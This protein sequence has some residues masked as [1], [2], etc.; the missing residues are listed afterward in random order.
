MKKTRT[1]LAVVLV[2]ALLFSLSSSALALSVDIDIEVRVFNQLENMWEVLDA[3]EAEAL[4]QG[5]DREGVIAAVK[6]AAK[7]CSLVARRTITDDEEGFTFT[8]LLGSN[9]AYNYRLRMYNAGSDEAASVNETVI[10]SNSRTQTASNTN[11]LLVGPYYGSDSSF[12]D[13]YKTEAQSIASY[14]GGTYTLLSGTNA[15]ATSIGNALASNGIVIFDS[16]G[17]SYNNTSY[18][19]IRSSTGLTSSDLSSSSGYHA[20]SLG[21][22]QYGIDGTLMVNKSSGTF[23]GSI[24]WMAICEGMMT[25]GLCDPLYN[26]GAEVVY[27]YSQSVSF[28]GDYAFEATFWTNMKNGKTVASSIAA[29]KSAHGNYDT[30]TDPNAYPVVRSDSDSYPSNPDSVQTVYSDWVLP[31]AGGTTP[32]ATP[33][34]APTATATP[35]ATAT[36]AP[37]GSDAYIQTSTITAGKEYII[38]YVSGSTAYV[39]TTTYQSTSNSRYPYLAAAS[40]STGSDGY[41]YLTLTN[42]TYGSNLSAFRFTAGGNSSSGYTFYNATKGYLAFDSSGYPTYVSSGLTE[43]TVGSYGSMRNTDY[44]ADNFIYLGVSGTSYLKYSSSAVNFTFYEKVDGSTTTT[45]T[46]VV[47][48]APTTAPTAT[49]APTTSTG[50]GVTI[51][52][53]GSDGYTGD[54]VVIYNG[55]TST[56]SGYSTGTMTGLIETT[57]EASQQTRTPANLDRPWIIDVDS[58]MPYAEDNG[59]IN[60]TRATYSVGDTKSYTISNY[61]PGGSSITFKVLAVGSHCYIWT[62]TNS[63][64]YPLDGIDTSFAATVAAEFDSK[65]DLMNSSFGDFRDSQSNGKVNLMFYN[66]DD[67]WEPG[68]GYVAGYFWSGDF[69]YNSAPMIHIDTMPGIQYTN[70]AGTTYIDLEDCYGTMVHEFQHLIN[71]SETSGMDTWLNE[72]F[73]GAAEEICYPGS[74]LFSR[75]RSWNGASYSSYTDPVKEYAYNSAYNLHTGGSTF[76]WDN[77]GDDIYAR[78]AIVMLM[79]QYMC[80]HASNGNG[81][82]KTVIDAVASGTAETTA[83]ANAMGMT[84]SDFTKNFATAMVANDHVNYNGLYSFTMQSGYNA[85]NYQNVADIYDLLGRVIFTGTSTTIYGGGFIVVKPVNNLYTPPSGASSSLK[86]VGITMGGTVVTPTATP[87]PVVTATPTPVV[88]AT[89]TPV[90]TATPTPV[91]TA[92]P[93]PVVTATPTPV[94]TATPTPVVTE[95]PTA[96]PTAAA[97]G[98]YSLVTAVTAGKQYLIAYNYSGT[99]YVMT[100]NYYSSGKYPQAVAATVT[101]NG[102]G[103]DIALSSGDDASYRLTAGGNSSSGWTFNNSSAGYLAFNSSGYPVFASSGLIE[104][105]Y[106]AGSLK[107]TDYSYDSYVYLGFN[108]SSKYFTYSKTAVSFVLYELNEGGTVTPTAEPTAAPTAEPT[109]AP[110][111]AEYNLVTSITAGKK[112]LLVYTSGSTNYAVTTT[113]YNTSSSRYPRMATASITANGTG[114]D[115]DMITTTYGSDEQAFLFTASASGTGWRFYNATKGYLAYDSGGYPTYTTSAGSYAVWTYSSGKLRNTNWTGDSYYYLGYSSSK[116]LTYSRTGSTF[117]LYELNEG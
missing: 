112:Y 33:T 6:E 24:F 63:A 37:S 17:C 29:M 57:I 117:K 115:I 69:S 84:I 13:Q 28:T 95:A 92:T 1:L 38:A 88:T 113:L 107:N 48:T 59:T 90:V 18:L 103:Y 46:P 73:S 10:F 11:V 85:A 52:T 25:N 89:P 110:S 42:T 27:G 41:T 93:T 74:G 101:A 83:L 99:T 80:S 19:C 5:L 70:T 50:E 43:W 98:E 45:P 32:T 97:G 64:Y 71:Y 75:I 8:T 23:P 34:V 39:P 104:W 77:N 21:S 9:C 76:T 26:N 2:L 51:D 61:S 30:Y 55:G 96:E 12:T 68:Q 60:A 20:Y 62:P 56:S 44:S 31:T 111:G 49:T 109:T 114:Y 66:I 91:V 100:T 116:Y 79:S 53:D 16:H 35:V 78:Y 40:V 65:Y 15:T 72:S 58:I 82:F 7:D 81:V 36:T 86:Y 94:V 47:T 22:S 3:A 67:G 106:S 105:T 54:Y 14:T 4:A 108:T 102:T 87:T